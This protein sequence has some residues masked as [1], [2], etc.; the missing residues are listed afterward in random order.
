M[1]GAGSP[2]VTPPPVKSSHRLSPVTGVDDQGLPSQLEGENMRRA[3]VLPSIPR[4]LRLPIAGCDLPLRTTR[5]P[6]LDWRNETE[7][8]EVAPASGYDLSARTWAVIRSASRR[9]SAGNG[10]VAWSMRGVWSGPCRGEHPLVVGRADLG[11]GWQR[12]LACRRGPC[13]GWRMSPPFARL[14]V[15]SETWGIHVYR[16]RSPPPAMSLTVLVNNQGCD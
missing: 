1:S 2:E 9:T 10:Y 12:S 13:L 6:R 11:E 14:G 4:Q 7:G 8:T 3:M 15:M 5:H 16:A